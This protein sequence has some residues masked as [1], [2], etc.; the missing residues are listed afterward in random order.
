[1]QKKMQKNIQKNSIA[2]RKNSRKAFT[3]I[4]IMIVLF[5]IVMMAGAAVLALNGQRASAQRRITITYVKQLAQ[6]LEFYQN[7]IGQPPS[8]EQGL[9]A[10]LNAPSDLPNPAKWNGPY[11]KDSAKDTDPW[12]NPYQYIA[13]GQ[14]TRDGFDVWSYG[15]DGINGTEDDI[16]NWTSD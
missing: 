9:A 11:L 4:E 12:G 16:G 1:M 6:A 14:H 15:P 3:L 10:L 8:T 13:P 5:I 2:D 7:D